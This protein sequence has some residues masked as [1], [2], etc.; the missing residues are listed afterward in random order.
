MDVEVEIRRITGDDWPRLREV[1]LEALDDTPEAFITT[2]EEASAFPDE[3]WIQRA[4]R[5]SA[6]GEQ[7]TFIA[8][9]RGRFVGLAIGLDRTAQ[10][11]GVFAIVSVFV[12]PSARRTSVGRRLMDAVEEWAREHGGRVTSLWVVEDNEVARSFYA[13]RGYRETLDR[14]K[15]NTPPVRWETRFIKDLSRR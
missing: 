12:S 9:R 14:Q 3:V 5:G 4:E 7:A 11:P 15:I 10:T 13:S 6:G 1:R 8:E 2:H